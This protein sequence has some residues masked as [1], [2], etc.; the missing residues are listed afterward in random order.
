M[1]II[2]ISTLSSYSVN[3]P[4]VTAPASVSKTCDQFTNIAQVTFPDADTGDTP[5]IVLTNTAD[6]NN[7]IFTIATDGM[8]LYAAWQYWDGWT[9]KYKWYQSISIF[10]TLIHYSS[11]VGWIS[12]T[13]FP[14]G[15]GSYSLKV[16]ASDDCYDSNEETIAL[17]VTNGMMPH[18]QIISIE[19]SFNVSESNANQKT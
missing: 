9:K 18:Q 19:Q 3:A 10:C 16:K 2:Q 15:I 11:F 8:Y 5:N 17:T 4:V 1:W 7:G 14:A 13:S 6:P 12:A